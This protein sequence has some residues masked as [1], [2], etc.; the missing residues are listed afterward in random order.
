MKRRSRLERGAIAVWTAVA[1]PAFIIVIGL[2]VDYSGHTRATQEARAVAA[3]AART[4]GQQISL[5]TGRAAPALTSGRIAAER[6]AE[7]SGYASTTT[8]DARAITVTVHGQYDTSF[9]GIIGVWSLDV[10]ASATASVES[11]TNN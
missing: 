7:R 8:V 4:G 11:V 10:E 1:L 3:E 6:F 5:A 2:G 9:L